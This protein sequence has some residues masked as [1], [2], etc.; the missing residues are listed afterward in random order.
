M[1]DA[2]DSKSSGGNTMRV[3]L[4]PPAPADFASIPVRRKEPGRVGTT[5]ALRLKTIGNQHERMRPGFEIPE[6][7][8]IKQEGRSHRRVSHSE[9]S[10]ST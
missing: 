8:R 7:G 1:A 10:L 5:S 3:Q 2:L 6:D 9:R 4:P